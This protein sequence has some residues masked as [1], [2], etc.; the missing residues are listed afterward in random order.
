VSDGLAN[1]ADFEPAIYANIRGLKP[2]LGSWANGI[3]LLI[4]TLNAKGS[5]VLW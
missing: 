5:V 1:N 2:T 3:K 4:R